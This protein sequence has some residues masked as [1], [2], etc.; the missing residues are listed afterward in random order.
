MKYTE[1]D[2]VEAIYSVNKRAKNCRDEAIQAEGTLRYQLL[3]EKEED[4]YALKDEFLAYFIPKEIHFVK[5]RYPEIRATRNHINMDRIQNDSDLEILRTSHRHI[6]YR[7]IGFQEVAYFLYYKIGGEGFHRPITEAYAKRLKL[8]RRRLPSS[9]R[10][11]G[12]DESE[13][14]PMEEVQNRL[15]Y[16]K[17]VFVVADLSH[18][19]P[20]NKREEKVKKRKAHQKRVQDAQKRKNNPCH[21]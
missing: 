17:K 6:Y 2:I 10:P 5:Y 3:K 13:L 1:K 19:L 7:R 4:L 14:L 11:M 12:V 18:L 16:V 21:K 8:S 15:E 20:K 9:F